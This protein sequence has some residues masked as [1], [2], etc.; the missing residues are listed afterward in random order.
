MNYEQAVNQIYQNIKSQESLGEIATY[1]PELSKVDPEKFGVCLKIIDGDEYGVGD[2]QTKF[3]IQ[4][5]SK[6]LSLSLAYKILGDDIWGR[7]GVEPS[8]N[9]FNS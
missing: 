6:V 7:V 9:P 5:I 1:I 2:W 3:S 8:G 4:S